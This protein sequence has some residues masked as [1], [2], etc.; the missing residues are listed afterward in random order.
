MELGKFVGVGLVP[1][2]ES[3]FDGYGRYEP[4]PPTN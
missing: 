1:G 2:G 3:V 4:C